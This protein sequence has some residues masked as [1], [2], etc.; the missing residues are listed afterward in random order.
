MGMCGRVGKNLAMRNYYNDYI[1]NDKVFKYKATV[2]MLTKGSEGSGYI[3]LNPCP[4][5]RKRVF[6]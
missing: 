2:V 3:L 6:L 4:T 1:T 5:A